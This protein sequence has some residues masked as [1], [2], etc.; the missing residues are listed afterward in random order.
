MKIEGP[1]IQGKNG[2]ILATWFEADSEGPAP[3]ILLCHGFPG[4]DQFHDLA[5]T[6]QKRG[7]HVMAFHYSGSWGSDGAYSLANGLADTETVLDALLDPEFNPTG[8]SAAEETF[9]DTAAAEG[10]PASAKASFSAIT[11]SP[12]DRSRVFIVGHSL[13]GFFAAHTFAHHPEISAAVLIS[14][15]D[16]AN[17]YAAASSDPAS[18]SDFQGLLNLYCAP[19]NGIDGDLFTREIASHLDSYR[20]SNILSGFG[21][22]P[23]LIVR[24]TRDVV[25]PSQLCADALKTGLDGIPG[26]RARLLSFDAPHDYLNVREELIG[27]VYAFLKALC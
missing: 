14:P 5:M 11:S 15:A 6:L 21:S 13:G 18:L 24:G 23:A 26:T 8:T 20:F 4:N 27:A 12:V 17:M 3:T 25:T 7:F 22:R 2:R 10:R 19:L 16:I 9:T 1:V